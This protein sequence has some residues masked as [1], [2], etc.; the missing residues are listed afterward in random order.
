M[1]TRIVVGTDGSETASEAVRQ[2][3]ELAKL[4]N[5]R[6]DIVS[7]YE[8]IPQQRLKE[9]SREAPGDVQ[10][11]ISAREDVNLTLDKAGG[12]ARKEK[13][14]EEVQTHAREGDPADAILD[15]AEEVNADLIVVGNKGMTGARRFLL[16]S[17]PNKV[18][19]H[20]PCSVVII[21]TT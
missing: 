17:V 13:G 9:E 16:G 18:S 1:F 21:R 3:T 11:E 15:V 7:A 14:I 6:L 19:H 2:A 10:Y 20:A 12:D 5:A 8:P 4:S